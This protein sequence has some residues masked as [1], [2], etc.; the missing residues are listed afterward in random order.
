MAQPALLIRDS[1][2]DTGAEP[3]NATDPSVNP[4]GEMWVSQDIWV[5]QSPMAGYTPY[6]F[7]SATPPLWLTATPDPN[8]DP[9]NRDPL[10]SQ[11]NYLYVRN[12]N[13]GRSLQRHG[14][15]SRVW[16]KASTG[17]S[18]PNQWVDY[19]ASDCGR[20]SR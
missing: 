20:A 13:V 12:S 11:P 16:A 3:D 4:N 19:M 8:Q 15:A 17:L 18:W 2:A 10:L 5:T 9:Q 7:S 6:P 1:P 14:A